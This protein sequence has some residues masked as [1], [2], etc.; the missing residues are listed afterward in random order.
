MVSDPIPSPL[1]EPAG[2]IGRLEAGGVIVV[3]IRSAGE[4]AEGGAAAGGRIPEFPDYA[5]SWMIIRCSRTNEANEYEGFSC[6]HSWKSV[7]S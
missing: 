4:F 5:L 6:H 2:L 7:N 1:P 3:K